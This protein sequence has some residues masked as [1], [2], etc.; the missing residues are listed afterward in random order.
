ARFGA[1][2]DRQRR[3]GFAVTTSTRKGQRRETI[4][5][6]GPLTA[7]LTLFGPV[8]LCILGAFA[9][10]WALLWAT[11]LQYDS[12]G[13]WASQT[14]IWGDWALHLGDVTS[15]VYGENFPPQN[16]RYAGTPLAYHYLTSITGAAFV[17]LGM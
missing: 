9:V 8:S 13:L 17:K 7:I 14:Y 3:L 4:P 2:A 5:G 11:A 6:P 16:T 1:L 15:F 12:R 10:R